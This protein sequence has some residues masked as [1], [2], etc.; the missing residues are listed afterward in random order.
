MLNKDVEIDAVHTSTKGNKPDVLVGQ[1]SE[2]SCTPSAICKI[3]GADKNV[4]II[5]A[6]SEDPGNTDE[7]ISLLWQTYPVV[8]TIDGDLSNLPTILPELANIKPPDS[9]AFCILEQRISRDGMVE[10]L[11]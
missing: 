2:I 7:S 3:D 11:N 4:L 10:P 6:Q 9:Q 1:D 5:K 8:E